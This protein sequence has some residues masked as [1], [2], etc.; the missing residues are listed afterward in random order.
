MK[1]VSIDG[2]SGEKQTQPNSPDRK[3]DNGNGV[4][5]IA[6]GEAGSNRTTEESRSVYQEAAE[7]SRS[8]AERFR[9]SPGVSILYYDFPDRGRESEDAAGQNEEVRGITEYPYAG[10]RENPFGVSR[11]VH[12]GTPVWEPQTRE[13]T[14]LLKRLFAY[15]QRGVRIRLAPTHFL[16]TLDIADD[17]TPSLGMPVARSDSVMVTPELEGQTGYAVVLSGYW[18]SEQVVLNNATTDEIY[19]FLVGVLKF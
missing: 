17:G 16:A 6:A 9:Q 4:C 3:E 10:I 7:R 12:V 19:D 5:T 11:P 2:V 1:L 14:E 8:D 18:R 15:F 13:L